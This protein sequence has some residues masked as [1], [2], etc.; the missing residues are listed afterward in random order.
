MNATPQNIRWARVDVKTRATSP[1]TLA[2]AKSFLNYAD[3]SQDVLIQSLI[4]AATSH[5]ESITN[6]PLRIWTCEGA[7]QNIPNDCVLILPYGSLDRVSEISYI[8]SSGAET[9]LATTKYIWA[10]GGYFR[11]FEIPDDIGDENLIERWKIEWACGTSPPQALLIATKMLVS[12]WFVARVAGDK[13]EG[14]KSA[15]DAILAPY[16]LP[17][18]RLGGNA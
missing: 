11:I 8:N 3:N 1:I 16:A 7:A 10:H 6:R 14:M 18:S 12:G 2:E 4:D 17:P 13:D 15:V 5:V 9:T